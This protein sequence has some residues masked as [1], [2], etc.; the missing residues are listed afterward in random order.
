M[1]VY[2]RDGQGDH[3]KLG[4]VSRLEDLL[5]ESPL[6]INITCKLQLQV[7]CT[8]YC[9]DFSVPGYKTMPV[10]KMTGSPILWF[11]SKTPRRHLKELYWLQLEVQG[12]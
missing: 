8:I 10:H 6:F 11:I 4:N 9:N 5:R 2:V 7:I 1:E 3:S 12:C